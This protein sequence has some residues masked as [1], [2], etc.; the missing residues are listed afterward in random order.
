MKKHEQPAMGNVIDVGADRPILSKYDSLLLN[1]IHR[2]EQIIYTSMHNYVPLFYSSLSL[3]RK[4][5]AG[6]FIVED[7]A[8]G[9][10]GLVDLLHG[11]LASQRAPRLNSKESRPIMSPGDSTAQHYRPAAVANSYSER[12]NIRDAVFCMS[13]TL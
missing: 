2:H 5:T 6:L 3:T 12:L 4:L 10:D 11:H 1:R 8:P 9:T 7:T 13:C